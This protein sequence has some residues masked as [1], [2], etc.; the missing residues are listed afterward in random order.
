MSQL[1]ISK[2]LRVL[3]FI[4]AVIA[5]LF[6]GW[7]M[8]LLVSD[9]VISNEITYLLALSKIG[10]YFIGIICFIALYYFYKVCVEIG[11]G[12]S[13][14]D[15]NALYMKRIGLMALIVGTL[16]IVGNIILNMYHI[17]N[18]AI[19]VLSFFLIMIAIVVAVLC[20]CLAELIVNAKKIKD[21]NDLTI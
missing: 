13:F 3:I 19:I 10:I 20:Y 4:I 6:F 16:I 11:K 17:L 9:I 7:Y 15:E 18:G 8:P 21:E 14:S 5:L 2:I 1:K 12:N